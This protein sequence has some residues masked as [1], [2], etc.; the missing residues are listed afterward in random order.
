MSE[1]RYELK[2]QDRTENGKQ[3]MKKLRADG[4][5][6]VI[7]YSHGSEVVQLKMAYPDVR[8]A[9][10]SGERIF[11]IH[12]AGEQRRAVIKELQYHPVTE[13]V[14]H[15]DL[16][17]V[18]LRD[19]VEIEVPLVIKGVPFGVKNEGGVLQ[20]TIHE[21]TV[22]CKGSDVPE[23][24]ELDVTGLRIGDAIHIRDIKSD[25]WTILEQGDVL[26]AIV[27]QQQKMEVET[28]ETEESEFGLDEEEVSGEEKDDE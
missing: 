1:T 18:R 17:G 9:I 10:R 16:H 25:V 26:L 27:Q 24:I 11:N 12:I 19:V 8:E 3:A 23:H 15:I 2:V 20:H 5:V 7:F 13:K 28:V 6:P 21:L 22:R 4:W 14:L